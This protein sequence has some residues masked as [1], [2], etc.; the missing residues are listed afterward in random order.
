MTTLTTHALTAAIACGNQKT[1]HSH[2]HAKIRRIEG[3][4][5]KTIRMAKQAV[6]LSESEG[7]PLRW[8]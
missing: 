7:E 5:G 8:R 2:I 3:E 6:K 1:T 4:L